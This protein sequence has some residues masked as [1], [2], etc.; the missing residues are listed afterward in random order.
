MRRRLA[1]AAPTLLLLTVAA[2]QMV[3]ARTSDLS[4]WK[5]G[6]FGMFSSV[7]G[8]PFRWTRIYVSAP[9]RSEELALPPSLADQADRV[10]T[11]PRQR[12]MESLARAVAARERRY[13]RPVESV[14][15]EVWRATVTPSLDVS[16]ALVRQITLRIDATDHPDDR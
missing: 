1:I 9:E 7:D 4:P 12:A 14:R 5:G 15:V 11:W 13:G 6:G 2:G 3:M 8:S 10:V 16:E